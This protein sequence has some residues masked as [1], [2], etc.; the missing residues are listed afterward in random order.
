MT[1]PGRLNELNHA[2]NPARPL[3]EW[4]DRARSRWEQVT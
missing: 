2:E 1:S 3:L 4:T